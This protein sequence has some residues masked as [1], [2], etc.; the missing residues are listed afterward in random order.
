MDTGPLE[1]YDEEVRKLSVREHYRRIGKANEEYLEEELAKLTI[2]EASRISAML[3]STGR[4]FTPHPY[5]D[6][7]FVPLKEL[8]RRHKERRGARTSGGVARRRRN[9]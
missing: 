7:D 9:S 8:I 3:L 2:E 4:Y 5:P 6:A 1:G